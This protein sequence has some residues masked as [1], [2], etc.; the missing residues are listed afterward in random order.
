MSDVVLLSLVGNGFWILVLCV[1]IVFFRNELKTAITSLGKIKVAGTHFT[2]N[3]KSDEVKAYAD[4]SDVFLSILAE[5]RLVLNLSEIVTHENA[6]KLLRFSKKYMKEMKSDEQNLELLRNIATIL[7]FKDYRDDALNIANHILKS[8]P[9]N[10]DYLNIKCHIL[11]N[12]KKDTDLKEAFNIL[13][14]L[15]KSNPTEVTFYYN[16]GVALV[17]MNDYLKGYEDI[18]K[19]IELGIFKINPSCVND[20]VFTILNNNLPDKPRLI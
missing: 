10:S 5:R 12:R 3:N 15:V 14:E 17:G 16:R 2:F 8:A 20:P 9:R 11:M 7:N 4:L 13:D 6:L 19:G 18:K 1:A